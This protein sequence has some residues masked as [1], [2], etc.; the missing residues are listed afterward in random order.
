MFTC[1]EHVHCSVHTYSTCIGNTNSST[2][3]NTCMYVTRTYKYCTCTPTQTVQSSHR[4]NSRR[5]TTAFMQ[6]FTVCTVYPDVQAVVFG[7]KQYLWA[8]LHALTQYLWAELHAPIQYLWVVLYAPIHHLSAV[9]NGPKLYLWAVLYMDLYVQYLWVVLFASIQCLWAVLNVT[10][11]ESPGSTICTY[12]LGQS[13]TVCNYT[14]SLG[15]C[16]L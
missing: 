14:E 8:E 13:N 4:P 1:T 15:K 11:A 9:L 5:I 16:V 6:G 3:Q 7:L 12:A 10:Y 2:V